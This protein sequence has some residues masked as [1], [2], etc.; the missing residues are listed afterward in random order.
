MVVFTIEEPF[1]NMSG[2]G[3]ACLT[4]ERQ[5]GV[6]ALVDIGIELVKMQHSEGVVADLLERGGGIALPAVVVEDDDTKFGTTVGRI[7]RDEV[8]D[9]DGLS[10]AVVYHHAHLTVGIDIVGGMGHVVVEQIAGIG[11]IG[12]TDAPER[13][14]VLDAVEQVEVFGLDGTQCYFIEH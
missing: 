13:R 9:A 6:I 2:D 4:E 8:D 3:K 7:E 5:R 1:G 14:I 12:G 11:H 10:L